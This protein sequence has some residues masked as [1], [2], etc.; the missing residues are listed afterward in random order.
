MHGH[1]LLHVQLS[2]RARGFY[3]VHGARLVRVLVVG[4]VG[5]VNGMHEE[6][7]MAWQAIVR[8]LINIERPLQL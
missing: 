7:V 6:V 5:V 2:E 3:V 4:R 8:F 1:S